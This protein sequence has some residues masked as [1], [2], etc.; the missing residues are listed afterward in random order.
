LVIDKPG[1]NHLKLLDTLPASTTVIV[2]NQ[3]ILLREVAQ[4]ADIILNGIPDGHLLRGIFAHANRLHWVH[5]LSSGVEKIIFPEL[6]ASPVILTNARGVFKRSL[7][8]FVLAT[9]LFFAKDLRRLVRSQEAGIWEQFEMAEVRGKVM[10]IV[11]YGE[12]GRAC[13][14]RAQ[15]LGMRVLGLRRRPE[16]SKGDPWLEAVFGSHQL[17]ALLAE[18][19]YVVLAAPST[20]QT[21]RLVG[22]AEFAV[23]KTSTVLINVGRGS[24]VDEAAMIEALERGR[25]RGA[26]MDVYE[27]EPLPRG[28]TFY[29]LKNLLLSPHCANHVPGFGEL[30]MECFIHN[31][32]RFLR[33]EP[34]ENVVDKDAGY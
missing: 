13:A 12:T 25:I 27:T 6:L 1:A 29:R 30:D 2:A 26:A 23:M 18:C 31:L 9:T 16:L 19:D 28:H 20:P 32:Q 3:S 21:Q 11:G 7:A 24:L 14:E 17:H 8:E 22:E 10:G 4:Q 15:A 34:L 5:S 33:G